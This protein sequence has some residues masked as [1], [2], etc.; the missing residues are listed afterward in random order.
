MSSSNRPTPTRVCEICSRRAAR[1]LVTLQLID[2]ADAVAALAVCPRFTCIREAGQDVIGHLERRVRCDRVVAAE[3]RPDAPRAP[4]AWA[5]GAIAL[6][7]SDPGSGGPP[8]TSPPVEAGRCSQHR[9]RGT[10]RYIG[11]QDGEAIYRCDAPR[12]KQTF[13]RRETRSGQPTGER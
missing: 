2:R 12:C 1:Y 13:R 3:P 9:C 6:E 4:A 8:P 11:F 10:L 7:P 5:P